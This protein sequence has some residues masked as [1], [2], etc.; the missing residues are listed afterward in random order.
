MIGAAYFMVSNKVQINIASV[1]QPRFCLT[2]KGYMEIQIYP[3]FI[4]VQNSYSL[5]LEWN[6]LHFAGLPFK[7][8]ILNLFGFRK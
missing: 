4:I 7:P 1:S 8:S 2:A 5:N 6:R 3:E